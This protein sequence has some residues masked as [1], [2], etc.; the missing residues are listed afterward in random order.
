MGSRGRT[1]GW[2]L[3]SQ[4]AWNNQHKRNKT[5]KEA[6]IDCF[7]L[8]RVCFKPLISCI[9]VFC[10]HVSLCTMCVLG[11]NRSQ[12]SMSYALE[13]K[14]QELWAAM[15]MLGI[16][17]RSFRRVLFTTDTYNWPFSFCLKE[18]SWKLSLIFTCIPWCTCAHT[19]N[20]DFSKDHLKMDCFGL[21]VLMT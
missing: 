13:L 8:K 4:L 15:L 20:A 11:V 6:W 14:L 9:R 21:Q 3:L 19:I 5:G 17:H 1:T 10:L 7:R 2:N 18:H 16:K 12:K